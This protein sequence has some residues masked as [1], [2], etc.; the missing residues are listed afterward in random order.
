MMDEN[1]SRWEAA[2]KEDL[3][4]VGVML[5]REWKVV[6]TEAQVAIDSLDHWMRDKSVPSKSVISFPS[7]AKIVKEPYGVA[8]IISPWNCES[9]LLLFSACV[10]VCMSADLDDFPPFF[11]MI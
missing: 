1:Q 7:S 5:Y 11:S 8:L 2:L 4:Q 6:S 10:C 3:G 9:R